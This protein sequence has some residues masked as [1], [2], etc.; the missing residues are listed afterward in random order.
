MRALN[1]TSTLILFSSLEEGNM[2]IF[3]SSCKN[4]VDILYRQVVYVLGHPD[5]LD[6]IRNGVIVSY[7]N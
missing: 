1:F 4:V 6:Y 2:F 5:I 7:L 3:S